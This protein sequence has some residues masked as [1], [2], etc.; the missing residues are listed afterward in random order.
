MTDHCWGQYAHNNQPIHHQLYM[1]M[2]KGYTSACAANAQARIRQVLNNLYTSGSDMFPGDED[3]G[4]MG[5]W[6]VLSSLGLYN[7]SP[8][9]EDFLFGAPLFGSVEVDISDSGDKKLI[10]EAVH[11]SKKNVY[12]Q[13][14]T[15]NGA[16]IAHTENGIKY[17]TLKEGGTLTFYMGPTPASK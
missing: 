9:G 6:Y 10:I 11:N 17:S 8:G 13:K 15:W 4:E 2:F 16:E 7:L 1:S 14:I 3:N 5:A 12:V